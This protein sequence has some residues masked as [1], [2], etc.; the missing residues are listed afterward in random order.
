MFSALWCVM[1]CTV[2]RQALH[3]N[4]QALH[5]DASGPVLW[6]I[7]PC[8]MMRQALHYD[9]QVRH[10]D[11]SGSALW[12]VRLCTVMRQAFHCDA[13]SLALWCVRPCTMMWQALHSYATGP[14]LWRGRPCTLMPQ[15][16]HYDTPGLPYVAGQCHHTS[17]RRSAPSP[18]LTELIDSASVNE[19]GRQLTQKL[20]HY[21]PADCLALDI[22]SAG[23]WWV[24]LT[25]ILK[26]ALQKIPTIHIQYI[27][28]LNACYL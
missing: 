28:K 26:Y 15:A 10:Y 6:C 3:C 8:T 7:R 25:F 14:A 9:G 4:R 19:A 1:P 18:L 27:L 11:A 13:S 21:F 20:T 24:T 5:C 22:E 23:L 17:D 16:L 2:M 12:C